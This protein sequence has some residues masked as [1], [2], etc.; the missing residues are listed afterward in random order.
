MLYPT[1][2]RA[3]SPTYVA[4]TRSNG[5][6]IVEANAPIRTAVTAWLTVQKPSPNEPSEMTRPRG[7]IGFGNGE[8]HG[9]NDFHRR[10]RQARISAA[11]AGLSGTASSGDSSSC[12]NVE[13]NSAAGSSA[14]AF[15]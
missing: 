9:R 1:E 2:L 12:R 13:R 10:A 11:I 5:K 6:L 15:Q 14:N 8:E 4:R 7:T 3:L